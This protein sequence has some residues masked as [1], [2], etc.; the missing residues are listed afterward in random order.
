[1]KHLTLCGLVLAHVLFYGSLQIAGQLPKSPPRNAT[2]DAAAKN[3][4]PSLSEVQSLL[5]KGEPDTALK[6]IDSIDQQQPRPKGLER[7]RGMAF[8]LKAS[9]LKADGAFQRALVEDPHDT[10][11]RQLRGVTLFRMGKPADAIPLLEQSHENLAALNLDGRYVLA[12]CYLNVHRFDESRRYFA[13]LYRLQPDSPPSYLLLARMLLRW[14][15]SPA[16]QEMAQKALT[17]NP[18]LPEAHLLLGQV[19]LG[20]GKLDEALSAFQHEVALNP[21]YGPVYDRLGDVYLQKNEFDR[22][23]DALNQALLLEPDATGPY[24]LLGQVLLKR[25]HP[26]TAVTFLKRAEQMDPANELTHFLLGQ[27]YRDL[28]KKQ[29]ATTEFQAFKKIKNSAKPEPPSR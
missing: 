8:Y 27:A 10:E 16:A 6:L 18:R 3:H 12:L 25:D 17:L 15:N 23:Q 29:D 21:M 7:L 5:D 24:I 22:A 26:A 4:N 13:E 20:E 2:S 11:S 14:K 1:V 9:F 28:G 19:A